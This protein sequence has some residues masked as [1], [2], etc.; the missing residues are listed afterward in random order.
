MATNNPNQYPKPANESIADNINEAQQYAH[1]HSATD[2]YQWFF[3]H[4]K[5]KGPWDFKQQGGEYQEFGNWH[6][7]VIGTAMGI[8]DFVLQRMAGLAQIAAGTSRPEYGNPLGSPPY[9]DDPAD[10]VHID[11]GITW[12]R[13][14]GSAPPEIF[15]NLPI[16]LPGGYGY[17]GDRFFYSGS[18]GI[19]LALNTFFL[20]ARNLVIRR[21]PLVLDLDGDGLELLP[22]SGAILFDHNADG[23]KTAT[24]WTHPNDGFLV[25]DL[26]S[27]G[28]IDTGRELFG[29][30]TLKNS[31]AL[32]ANGFD[33]LREL[34]SNGDGQITSADTAF[35]ELK[36]W[37]DLNQDGISQAVE[38]QS[39][40]DLNITSI[41][42]QGT[43]TGPQAFQLINNNRVAL[44]STFTQNTPDGQVTRTVG[45]IDLEFNSFFA[46][47]PL[48][49][50]VAITAQ[51]Q[52]LPQMNGAGMVRNMREAASLDGDFAAALTSFAAGGTRGGQRGMLGD[53]IT[54]WAHTSTFAA[55]GFLAAGNA[56]ITYTM[57]QGV[58]VGHFIDMI[59]VL[60]AF[61]GSRFY[62]TRPGARQPLGFDAVSAVD[63][64]TGYATVH[65]VISPP[66][67]Q[68]ALLQQA[69]DAL[70]ESVYS[71]LVVQTRL[72]PYT[73]NIG[74]VI[75]Q[76]GLRFDPAVSIALVQARADG[77]LYEG[78]SD[79]IDLQRY[80]ADTLRATGWQPYTTLGNILE[81]A[82]ITPQVQ[83]FLSREHIVSLGAG[84]NY[85][86]TTATGLDVLGNSA[87]NVLLGG[88]GN[89]RLYG[90]AGNDTLTGGAGLNVLDGG[91]GDDMLY[92]VGVS[93]NILLGGAGNDVLDVSSYGADNNVLE[94]GAGND[95]ISGSFFRDTYRFNVGDGQ[96]TIHENQTIGA[97]PIDVLVFGSGILPVDISFLRS[98]NNMV[99]SHANGVDKI[100]VQ[101]WFADVGLQIERVDFAD[102]TV[103]NSTSLTLAGL[104]V[105]G[106]S[107]DDVMTGTVMEDILRGGAGND[108]LYSSY[109][110]DTL[111]GGDGNDLLTANLQSDNTTYIGGKGNDI[112]FG[113]FNRD[114]Y[115]F[116]VGDGQDTI[117]ENQ[118][119][120][121]TPIDKLIFGEEIVSADISFLRMDNDIVF[122]HV[123]GAD[124]ITVKGW[125]ADTGNQIERVFFSDGTVWNSISMTLAG[126]E[127]TGT[128]G[129]DVMTGTVMADVLHGGA[130]N[131]TLF[132]TFHGDTLD[133]GD[134]NDTLIANLQSDDTT[135]IGGKGDDTIFG[136]FYRDTYRFNAGDGHD[137]ITE[138]ESNFWPVDKLI[139]G[140]GIAVSDIK[141]QRIGNDMVFEHANGTDKVTVKNWFLD[142][143]YQIELIKFAD[144][145]VWTAAVGTLAGLTVKG[146]TGNDT[147][148]GGAGI[149]VIDGGDGDDVLYGIQ[150]SASNTLIGGAGNDTLSVFYYG[151]D[152]NVFEGGT[153]NDIIS[154]TCFTDTY[155]FN[156]GDG[157]DTITEAESNFRPTDRLIFGPGIAANDIKA[158][159]SGNDMVFCHVNGTDKITVK[160]WFVDA[161]YQIERVEFVDS[162]VWNSIALTQAALNHAPVAAAIADQQAIETQLFTYTLPA[163]TFTDVDYGDILGLT[164]TLANGAA[165]PAWLGFDAATQTFSGAPPNTAS[166]LLAFTVTATDRMGATA[167]ASFNVDIINAV[168]GTAN[169]DTLTGTAARDYLYGLA[170]NDILNGGLGADT[171]LGGLGN[172]TYVVDNAG[173]VVVELAGEGTDTV[174]S[175]ISYA[176]AD[177]VENLTL[178]GTAAINGT[179]NAL[180]NVLTGNVASNV[181]TG[182]DGNDTLN[183]GAGAD[184]LI[185]GAGNDIYVVDN[186]GD[187]VVEL[188]GFGT[189]TVQSSINTTLA[190][191]VENLTLTGTAAI[192]GTGN[193]L[194]NTITGNTASNILTGGD[195]NDSLNG[196]AG[197]DTLIG[198][199]GND[200][201]TVDNAGDVVVEMA[202]EGTDLVNASVS[203]TLANNV[204]N[205]TLT[206]SAAIN[207]TG[208]ALANV[209]TGNAAANTLAGGAGDDTLNGGGGADVLIGGTGND[210]YIVDNAADI[211]TELAGEGADTVQASVSY[212]LAANVENLTLAGA[213]AISAAGN[214]LDNSLL[215]NSAANTL[216][217]GAGNDTLNGGTGADTLLG[218]TGNDLYI[219]DNAGDVVTELANEGLDTVNSSSSYALGA[220]VENLTLLG[221][222]AIN[223][224]GNEQAN[225]LTGNA[226]NNILNGGMGAD[227]LVGGLG[228]DTYT[229]DNPADLVIEQAG[230]GTDTVNASI[231]YTLGANLENLT[232]AGTDN[233]TATGNA[234]NNVFRGN[235]GDNVLDGGLG[236]D[237]M[238]GSTGNDTYYVDNI[239]D[240]TTEAASAGTDTVNSSISWTLATNLENLT[241]AAGSGNL[242]ATGNTLANVLTGNS[243]DNILNGGTG[244]DT[245]IGG[246]GND[247]YVVDNA[248]DVVTELAGEGTDSVNATVSY[249]LGANQENLTLTGTSSIA[250][251]GN[252]LANTFIGN[253]G[254]NV[255]T[256]GAGNDTLNGGAGTDTLI[257]GTGNDTYVMGRGYGADTLQENDST[258]GN[259]DLL[260][261]TGGIATDQIWLRKVANNLEVSVI[262]TTD[263]MTISNWYLGS[264]YH[265]ETFQTADGKILLDS[266]V[267]NLVQTMAAFAPPAAGQTTLPANYQAS[268]EPQIAANWH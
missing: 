200:V 167:S 75:D 32:A 222:S 204:E 51:T 39:L 189:D 251:T 4:V 135:Y 29:E 142:A 152:N 110:G 77:D 12:A 35:S 184:T 245:M 225:M 143:G 195:G 127:V 131:D 2:S 166:G 247:T 231:S 262:G 158:L 175:S 162:T 154:A 172:D 3:D 257:G 28:V 253:A 25:H 215:G 179:G 66:A 151:P 41:N 156:L 185:G 173:D 214:E 268:L 86:V 71:A 38:L 259:S 87:A 13:E 169:N 82:A 138:A 244:A 177:N 264:Q 121:P 95:E 201:Y 100:T 40:G 132:S 120:G 30:D 94:G 7:G 101:G 105:T 108:T 47:F 207:G 234:L 223:A 161:G 164:A 171:M 98:G 106:T 21:D 250:G 123:N 265:V 84:A 254:N 69:Y 15:P 255:L 36:V 193:A 22:A 124:N 52:G 111:D 61:N 183:G 160:N 85:S 155:K 226:G 170:G 145:T 92:G 188:A 144:S 134:G 34:D 83:D 229:V 206:G 230:E 153:G 218:G 68:V 150:S 137:T 267:Q 191:N 88:A 237:T 248:A 76:N 18:P 128:A 48:G 43:T 224:T 49:E 165:L 205:L 90:L 122:S 190:D 139:F 263:K 130:G 219:V 227:T 216:T 119:I 102:G 187:I 57:P 113:S 260:Q 17:A 118:T 126:L 239:G 53:V 72:K 19:D 243:G 209:L 196:G 256:G 217:G 240:I 117:K 232:L 5:N 140:A 10:Q 198:G 116:N 24:G 168:S 11:R 33:A 37:R 114:T 55:G 81:S 56:V 1:T 180:G 129:D 93:N 249:T 60:E 136:S 80:Q 261:F 9:G 266:Q 192:N 202:G 141:A 176:L 208:N 107:G 194:G 211:V 103:L 20:S 221:T 104:E 31:G 182:G 212:S 42:T 97:T 62:G 178:T 210:L 203:Y 6:Y 213:V 133:G 186:A 112:I 228:N 44:S 241:L 8:P 96:D 65:Y 59:N 149:N 79:L 50:P 125:F 242:N 46:Q 159:R 67:A 58:S 91:D 181:L 235:A 63:P 115:L 89:D 23:I 73:D 174:Q 26:N 54:K 146:T 99:F 70:K 163:S 16:V 197:A 258:A 233:L 78:V 109:Y 199:G 157:Q 252:E 236:A 45:A 14:N 148:I 74:L 246:A 64:V 27:N 238:I 220:N 147:I